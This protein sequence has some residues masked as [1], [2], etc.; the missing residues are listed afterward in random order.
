MGFMISC[1][2]VDNI[3]LAQE[4]MNQDVHSDHDLAFCYLTLKFFLFNKLSFFFPTYMQALRFCSFGINWLSTIYKG[5]IS[6]I[7]VINGII[8]NHSN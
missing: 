7:K 3:F 1:N 8:G 6:T 5:F 4:A 2:I